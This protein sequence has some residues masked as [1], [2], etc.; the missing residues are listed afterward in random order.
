MAEPPDLQNLAKQYL[1][2]WQD[3]LG[4]VSKDPQTVEIMA[5]TM[6]LM[7]AG[8][9]VFANMATAAQNGMNT[10]ETDQGDNDGNAPPSDS[11]NASAVSQPADATPGAADPDLAEF[12]RRLE[13]IEERLDTLE[14][15]SR[16]SRRK[17]AKKS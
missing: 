3:Q 10:G 8:A 13:R 11:S 14:A 17:S 12:A 4:G 7:N 1:D 6:Q 15:A 5:Q 2:L 16:K 9:Q